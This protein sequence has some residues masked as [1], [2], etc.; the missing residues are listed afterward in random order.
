MLNNENKSLIEFARLYPN[1]SITVNCEDLINAFTYVLR[2]E[3]QKKEQIS[4][5]D[6]SDE[7]LTEKEVIKILNTSRSSLFRWNRANYLKVVK[8]GRKNKYR[9]SDVMKIKNNN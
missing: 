8:I 5:Q 1:L 9:Y 7:L 2:E 4:K 3:I 6:E